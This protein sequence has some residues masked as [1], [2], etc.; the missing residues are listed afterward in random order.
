MNP[1]TIE[2]EFAGF[3]WPRYVAALP[4]PAKT[5]AQRLKDKRCDRYYSNGSVYYHAPKPITSGPHPGKGFYLEA[6]RTFGL[7][8]R[9]CDEV[10]SH[11]IDHTG[12]YC[13]DW[14]GGKIRGFV[15]KLP[16][17][18]GFLIGWSMGEGMA[19]E[20]GGQVF[21][22]EMQ[23]AYAA[24]SWAE[25]IAEDYREYREQEAAARRVAW[26]REK[27]IEYRRQI[28]D[29]L[30]EFKPVKRS[31]APKIAEAVRNEV[32]R[33]LEYRQE[34]FDIIANQGH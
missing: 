33:L 8:S 15:A 7:R 1:H 20:I 11:R 28:L 17:S 30:E 18:R 31:T 27:L 25:T 4:G 10:A 22:D 3:T 13:D 12:W 23:A 5:P 14:Q 26:A 19:S 21:Y 29:L 16:Q 34:Q 24:D 32:S 6:G 9:W 2:F